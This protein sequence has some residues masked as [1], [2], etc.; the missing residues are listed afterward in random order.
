MAKP[1]LSKPLVRIILTIAMYAGVVL[2]LFPYLTGRVFSGVILV[3]FGAALAVIAG[4]DRCFLT[5]GGCTERDSIKQHI[6]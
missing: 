3:I 4:L 1:L 6:P 5:E 2:F